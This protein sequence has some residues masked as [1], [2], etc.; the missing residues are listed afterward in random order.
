M[1]QMKRILEEQS[2]DIFNFVQAMRRQRCFMVQTEAQYIF[3]H[4]ALLEVIECG[5][6]EMA[7][8]E[9][10]DRVK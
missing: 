2:V 5:R 6:T 7:A 8:R 9:V 10:K 3:I 4:D 1:C